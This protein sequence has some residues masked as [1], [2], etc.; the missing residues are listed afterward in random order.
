M[1]RKHVEELTSESRRAKPPYTSQGSGQLG[2]PYKAQALGP[3]VYRGAGNFLIDIRTKEL[4][5]S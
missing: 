1:I 3:E 4:F 2:T 5:N